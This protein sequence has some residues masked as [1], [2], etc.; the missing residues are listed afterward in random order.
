MDERTGIKKAQLNARM[1]R[2]W[3]KII[4]DNGIKSLKKIKK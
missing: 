3:H 1:G 2:K 4:T